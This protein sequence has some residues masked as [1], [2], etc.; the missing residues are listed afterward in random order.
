M[1]SLSPL[2]LILCALAFTATVAR[3]QGSLFAYPIAITGTISQPTDSS[4]DPSPTK[5]TNLT[6]ASLLKLSGN[7]SV[8]PSTTE[9]F[10]SSDEQSVVL[11][12]K[13]Q[14]TTYLTVFTYGSFV[15]WNPTSKTSSGG[16]SI[17][18]LDSN[19]TGAATYTQA[20][21]KKFETETD[22]VL[23]YGTYNSV[24]TTIHATFI[25]KYPLPQ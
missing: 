19:L 20:Y 8:D 10:L 24:T 11:A 7:A 25:I 9:F 5:V 14:N 15:S 16:G 12:S 6:K 4:A 1:K 2:F 21:G 3:A 18:M 23:A 22:K 17:S 13:D